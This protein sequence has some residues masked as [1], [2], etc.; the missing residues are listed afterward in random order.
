MPTS[1]GVT[2]NYKVRVDKYALFEYTYGFEPYF[3]FG[4]NSRGDDMITKIAQGAQFSLVLAVCISAVN[5]FIGAIY[6]AIEG[7]Y[8]GITDLVMERI[9]DILGGINAG[10]RTC[11]FNPKKKRPAAH[12]QPDYEIDRLSKLLPLLRTL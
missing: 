10:I 1:S 5:L 11:W 9:S 2:L 7:F 3:L 12:I 8:G 6:G 4:T